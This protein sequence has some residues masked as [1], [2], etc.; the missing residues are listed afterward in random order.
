[1][2]SYELDAVFEQNFLAKSCECRR[3]L[4]LGR[5]NLIFLPTSQSQRGKNA[6]FVV[7]F[8]ESLPE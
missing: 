4:T 5:S 8:G 1:M 7:D 3:W 2:F 6:E